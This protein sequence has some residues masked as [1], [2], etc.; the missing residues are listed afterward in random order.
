MPQSA[1]LAIDTQRIAVSNAEL[2]FL[3]SGCNVSMRFCI[4]IRTHTQADRC[5]A[6]KLARN[7]VERLQFAFRFDVEA[8]DARTKCLAHFI[9]CLADSGKHRFARTSASR[10]YARQLPAGN[11]VKTAAQPGEQVQD[12]KI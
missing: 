5:L 3:A 2:V 6:A 10:D 8:Q 12:G 9:A 1:R 7:V 4:D 11:D